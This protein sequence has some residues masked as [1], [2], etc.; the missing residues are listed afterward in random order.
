MGYE[1]VIKLDEFTVAGGNSFTIRFHVLDK[2]GIPMDLTDCTT[3][4][5]IAKFGEIR[6][7]IEDVSGTIDIPSSEVRY[8]LTGILTSSLSGKYVYQSIIETPS[9]TI[10]PKQGCFLVISEIE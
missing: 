3:S 7:L 10:V 4:L 9:T 6:E 1:N 2:D 8:I 5:K